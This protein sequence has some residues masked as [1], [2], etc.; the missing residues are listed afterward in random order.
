MI[1]TFSAV[2]T[3]LQDLLPPSTYFRFNPYLSEDFTLDEI[4]DEKWEQLNALTNMYLR[5]NQLKLITA[6]QV[7]SQPKQPHRRVR[8]WVKVTL[9]ERG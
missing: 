9:D 7:L 3:M 6:A 1:V 4:R 5:K 2:H 8:D